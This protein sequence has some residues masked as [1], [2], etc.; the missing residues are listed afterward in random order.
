MT[1]SNKKEGKDGDNDYFADL[2]SGG[3]AADKLEMQF[4]NEIR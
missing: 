1:Q 2:P 3:D 4:V